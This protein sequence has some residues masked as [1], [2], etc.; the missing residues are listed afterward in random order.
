MAT[1][2]SS[3]LRALMESVIR[4]GLN[5]SAEAFIPTVKPVRP[6]KTDG[7]EFIPGR[8]SGVRHLGFYKLPDELKVEILR[9]VILW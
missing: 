6:L 1:L 2:T 4:L 3:N 5:S 9:L 7:L 8:A